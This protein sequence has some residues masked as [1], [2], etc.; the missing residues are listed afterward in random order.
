MV[1]PLSKFPFFASETAQLH[2]LPDQSMVVTTTTKCLSTKLWLRLPSSPIIWASKPLL[3]IGWPQHKT[4]SGHWTILSFHFSPFGSFC[5]NWIFSIKDNPLCLIFE[6][7]AD[8]KVTAFS[9]LQQPFFPPC[10]SFFFFLRLFIYSWETYTERGR[11]I[12]RR[13][14]SRLHA[15]TTMRDSIPGL[16]D[17]TLS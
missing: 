11:D 9:L 3:R 4:F 1:V 5:W 6:T 16:Q 10:K 13:R 12:G 7:L 2:V 14:R 17:H 15:E 8:L